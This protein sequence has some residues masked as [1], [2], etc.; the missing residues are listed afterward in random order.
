MSWRSPRV[1]SLRQDPEDRTD[2]G[3]D[4][5]FLPLEEEHVSP[6]KQKHIQSEGGE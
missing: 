2:P 4:G 3:R 6:Y 5:R 1:G